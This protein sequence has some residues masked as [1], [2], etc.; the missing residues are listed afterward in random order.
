MNFDWLKSKIEKIGFVKL[1]E[2]QRISFSSIHTKKTGWRNAATVHSGEG[3][4]REIEGVPQ[5]ENLTSDDL[6]EW[7]KV[8]ASSIGL[9]AK[10]GSQPYI[11]H[12]TKFKP[13]E[14]VLDI[15]P[16]SV[17]EIKPK[18]KQIPDHKK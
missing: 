1:Q 18:Q 8:K 3:A 17:E 10:R 2:G 14:D 11:Y 13:I 6:G 16:I 4:G 7:L 5:G 15:E 9:T 12:I